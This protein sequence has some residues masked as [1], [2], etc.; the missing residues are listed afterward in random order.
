MAAR[1]GRRLR[2]AT[3]E[4]T[5]G[6]RG[7]VARHAE[8]AFARLDRDQQALA[9]RVL[10]RLAAEDAGGTIERRRI[11]LAELDDDAVAEVVAI[12]TDQRLLTV[13]AGAVELAHDALLRE[14]PRLRGWLEDDAEGRRLH[15]RLADAARQWDDAGRDAGDL[16]RG[17]RLA[18]ALEW[19]DP[20]EPDLNRTERDFLDAGRDAEQREHHAGQVRRRRAIA[21]GVAVLAVITGI[22]TIL[23]VGS[24]QRARYEQRAGASR[25]LATRALARLP[26]N[27]DLA[28]LLALEAYRR[29]PT[30]EAR[31][32]VLSVPPSLASYRRLGNPLEHAT[33]IVSIAISHDGRTL[34]DARDDGTIAL[35][36]V[37]TRRR[38]GRLPTG[39]HKAVH[40]VAFSPDG[41]R[42][43]SGGD[44]GT[45]RLWDVPTRRPIGHPLRQHD[46][47]A[48]NGVA[49]SPDGTTL[50]S[51]AN[52]GPYST[53]NGTSATLQFWDVAT[54]R[55]QGAA[56]KT[57]TA[58]V[59][60][61]GISADGKFLATGSDDTLQ[62]WDPTT[63]RKLGP[64][65]ASH[66]DSISAVAFSPDGRT[67]ASS[68]ANGTVRLW[69]VRAQRALGAPLEGHD[70]YVNSV[71][72]SPD[73]STLASG[74]DDAT[75]RLWSVATHRPRGVL[76]ADTDSPAA[77]PGGGPAVKRGGVQPARRDLRQRGPV[78]RDPAVGHARR[79]SPQPAAPRSPRLGSR[80][81][82]HGQRHPRLGR[83]RRQRA[84][85]GRPP[86]ASTGR[87]SERRPRLWHGSSPDGR[88]L[89][90][91][92]A[93]GPLQIWDARARRL[94]S[95][96]LTG[97]HGDVTAVAFSPDRHTLASGGDDGTVRFWD[98]E[99]RH[100]SGGRSTRTPAPST[101]SP[102][103]P[104]ARSSPSPSTTGRC[105]CGTSATVVRSTRPCAGRPA[106]WPP[107]RSAPTAT[108]WP[109]PAPTNRS[110]YGT[111]TGGAHSPRRSPATP[112]FCS[113]SP[114]APTAVRSPRP[115]QTTP[116]AC[117]TCTPGARSANRSSTP[118][119]C[120]PSPSARAAGRSRA[121]ATAALSASG[122]RSS[123]AT[124]ATP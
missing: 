66:T 74:S 120:P 34:A 56:L 47:G 21:L 28:G 69:D 87:L 62:L 77:C 93:N 72:F 45:V 106:S 76:A 124:T 48:V 2:L 67:L 8:D 107:W 42:L 85:V 52:E 113:R 121:P 114:S 83:H 70:N 55:A 31:S 16:Y 92:G 108:S 111:S 44:N 63:G 10:L 89:A 101:A 43:A 32:A 18:G 1:D 49:F 36:E 110:G 104:T 94:L 122:T 33:S 23:A 17:A 6:V 100:P 5:G 29:E 9:R 54:G 98:A 86:R 117:G 88:M 58:E 59:D 50:A 81:R 116:C 109:A 25:A 19:R 15:R 96:S 61:L 97:H 78:R 112:T 65:L 80:P 4:A 41:T 11:A 84:A 20:H 71:A 22:S 27:H 90:V 14:W 82:L 75:V 57:G 91:G 35:W 105:A 103:A 73:G 3:Y 37:A 68:G 119:G 118:A 60:A 7:A 46:A 40:A 26:D 64:P 51:G 30:I 13:S 99:R 95:P 123:G 115:G 79:T 12:L 39:D 24:I 53:G 102:S 38:L